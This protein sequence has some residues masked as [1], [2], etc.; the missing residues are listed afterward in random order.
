MSN[1]TRLNRLYGSFFNSCSQFSIAPYS[2]VTQ[3]II[4]DNLTDAPIEKIIFTGTFCAFFSLIVPILPALTML[5]IELAI[6]AVI[7]GILVGCFAYPIA[8]VMDLF[9]IDGPD[10]TECLSPAP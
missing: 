10:L 6:N 3:A 1:V 8:A 7:L 2:L 5:T 9:G 4:G